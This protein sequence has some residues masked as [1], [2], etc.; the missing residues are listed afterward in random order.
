MCKNCIYSNCSTSQAPKVSQS[1]KTSTVEMSKFRAE[2][3]LVTAW[4]KKHFDLYIAFFVTT[5]YCWVY[6][7]LEIMHD[8][9]PAQTAVCYL[10]PQLIGVSE[11]N[12]LNVFVVFLHLE[13]FIEEL[14]NK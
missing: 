6:N 3:S 7:L 2:Q 9:A 4:Y 8:Q 12:L 13:T 14:S 11:L 5:K 10:S 1:P